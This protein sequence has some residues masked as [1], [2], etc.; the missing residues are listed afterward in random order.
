ME[1]A[2]NLREVADESSVEGHK[3]YERLDIPDLHWSWPVC[4]SLDFNRVH[5]YVVLRDNK[6]KVIHLSTFELALLRLEEEL[7]GMEGLE[8]LSGDSPMVCERGGIDEYVVHI[9][10]GL[11]AVDEGAEDVVHHGLEGGR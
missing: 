1:G 2:G 11:I 9:A 8:Y 5:R 10:D 4:D 3:P 7:V 6:P